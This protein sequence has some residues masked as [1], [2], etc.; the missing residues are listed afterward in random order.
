MKHSI[1]KN[2]A[3]LLCNYCLDLKKGEKLYVKSSTLA[4]PLVREVYREAVK[5]GVHVE[6]SLDFR[7]MSSIFYRYADD[8]QLTY[9]NVLAKEA[10]TNFDAYLYIR[11]PYNLREGQNIDPA[12]MAKK[13][14]AA[15]KMNKLYFERTA[16]G[17]MRRSLCQYPTLA[18]AQEAGMTMEE[19]SD[20]VYRACKLNTENPQKAWEELG[21]KQQAIVDFLNKCKH[22]RYVS[23]NTDIEFS[24]EGRTWINS[25]GKSNM[26]SG[27]VFTAPVEDSVNG[28]IEFSY[29]SIYRGQ[30]VEKVRLWVKDGYIEKWEADQGKELLDKVFLAKGSR[31]FGEAAIGTN[32]DIQKITKN[33][34]FDEKIGGSIHMAVGQSY[35]QCGGKNESPIHWDMITDMK[36]SGAIYAD[37]E[38]IY[39]NGRFLIGLE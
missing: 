15:S 5:K 25:D 34:L 39:E 6:Y 37:G 16:S 1:L 35:K 33:I 26:P 31:R 10:M 23:E 8:D 38:Q 24:T 12:K 22:I 32:Y 9:V 7:G 30:S 11:A 3:Q 36:K 27:E 17:E 18:N 29:P 28:T 19:Y 4:E 20:F 21:R 13:Q 14:E 2:Y